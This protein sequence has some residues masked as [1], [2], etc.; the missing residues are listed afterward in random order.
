MRADKQ[1]PEGAAGENYGVSLE[2]HVRLEHSDLT[3]ISLSLSL[4]LPLSKTHNLA[5]LPISIA[6]DLSC[7]KMQNEPAIMRASQKPIYQTLH[8]CP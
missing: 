4:F 3:D 1:R 7:I 5:L 8:L 6:D 2:A